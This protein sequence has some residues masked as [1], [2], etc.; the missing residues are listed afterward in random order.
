[1][2]ERKGWHLFEAIGVELEY[3][4]VDRQSLD[5]RPVCDQLFVSVSGKVDA[6]I[7]F[8]DIAWS[9]ELALHV[10]E[11]K[12]DGPAASLAGLADRFQEHVRKINGYAAGQGWRLMPGAMHPWMDPD[13][14]MQLWPHEYTAV[15]QA[16]NRIFDCRGHGWSNLQSTHLNLPFLGDEEFGRLHAAIRLVLPLLPALAASSPVYGGRISG[17]QDSRMEFYRTNSQRV[18]SLTAGIV[19]EPVFTRADYEREIFRRI[20]AD[21]APLDPEGVLQDE[22]LNSRGAIARFGRG[23]IEIRVL[24]IQECPQADLALAELIVAVLKGLCAGRWESSE[25][26]QRVET[27]GLQELMRDTIRNGMA[28]VVE[29][30][31]L[32]RQ[33]G[34]R[35]GRCT[36]GELWSSLAG[37]LA[38]EDAGLARQM[39]RDQPL[40]VVLRE[41]NLAERILRRLGAAPDRA[42]LKAVWSELCD[43]LENGRMF[44]VAPAVDRD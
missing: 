41:G 14:E 2:A 19:P 11:M 29:S 44:R 7:S 24:D 20:Y 38:G 31:E 4:L 17:W 21:I 8:G 43:C 32:R 16:Y 5:V 27:A 26:Q 28:T 42:V 33:F 25:S 3:M 37:E 1:M 40:E 15:Y 10:V 13:R 30:A 6:D 18:P 9:N 22:F 12:T 39:E 23:S 36:V 34:W 35:E